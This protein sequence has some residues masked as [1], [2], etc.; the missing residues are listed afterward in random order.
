MRY[1]KIIGRFCKAVPMWFRLRREFNPRVAL[2]M[3]YVFVLPSKRSNAAYMEALRRYF[4]EDLREIVEEYLSGGGG[5]DTLGEMPFMP[6]WTCWLGGYE[7]MPEIVKLCC[8]RMAEE[9]PAEMAK[10]VLITSENYGEYIDVPEYI[11]EKYRSG[12]IS[13]AHFSDVIRFCLL[14]RYGGMW[15]DSTVYVSDKI[16]KEYLTADYY[17]Q[18]ASIPEQH[19]NEPS[20]AQWCG[21]IW[22]GRKGNLLFSFVRDGLFHYWKKYDTVIDYIFFDYIIKTAHDC[23]PPIREMMDGQVPNNDHIW[24]LWREINEPY[25]E[26]RYETICGGNVF[27]KLSYKADLRKTDGNQRMTM[28][29]HLCAMNQRETDNLSS[30][31]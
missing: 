2:W 7:S 26:K 20:R 3:C 28:Y 6:V 18:K 21:F 11:L 30:H 12:I 8:Q 23:I 22:S 9:I 19:L 29:G 4:S 14:S 1:L 31:G 16:P 15:L 13:P 27:H 24:A 5:D 10:V 17:T 25:D